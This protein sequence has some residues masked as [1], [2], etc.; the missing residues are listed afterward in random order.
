M[1]AELVVT[2]RCRIYEA[3]ELKF[4]ALN[5]FLALGI[6]NF[7]C[8]KCLFPNKEAVPAECDLNFRGALLHKKE[9][10]YSTLKLH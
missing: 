3:P 4:E 6:V 5:V 7:T 8:C 9:G 2:F 1:F 10:L